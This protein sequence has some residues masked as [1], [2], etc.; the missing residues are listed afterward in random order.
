MTGPHRPGQFRRRPL[1]GILSAACCH[2]TSLI[3]ISPAQASWCGGTFPG[4]IPAA[5]DELVVPF[6]AEP[7]YRTNI[8]VRITSLRSPSSAK[9]LQLANP[10]LPPILLIGCPG[11]GYEYLEN[12]EACSV[13]GRQVI[14]VNTCEAPIDRTGRSWLPPSPPPGPKWV[15]RPDV[16]AQ[17]ILAVCY[18]CG[19]ESVH[20]FAH[21]LG[22]SVALHLAASLD[23]PPL[24]NGGSI[25]ESASTSTVC[26]GGDAA[27]EAAPG[28]LND[29][30]PCTRLASIVLASPYGSIQDLTDLQ[31]QRMVSYAEEVRAAMRC[32]HHVHRASRVVSLS[33]DCTAA[34]LNGLIPV[35]QVPEEEAAYVD[36]EQC[37]VE[38]TAL[39]S[40]P[41]REAL[42]DRSR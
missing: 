20:V 1:V 31:Q 28:S 19:V 34:P 27:A 2:T 41:Y 33:C 11:V 8:F 13:S 12:L 15:R 14:A 35:W 37:V 24:L 36:G 29:R 26:A 17:Q 23:R 42:L 18:A 38:A 22:A 3:S 40:V 25:G 5:W 4:K 32:T 16:A 9:V 6:T 21:G 10:P 7:L 39:T 30:K